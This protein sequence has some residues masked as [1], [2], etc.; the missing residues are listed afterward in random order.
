MKL[1]ASESRRPWKALYIAR[2]TVYRKEMYFPY[3][4]RY[5]EAGNER[6][7][8]LIILFFFFKKVLVWYFVSFFLSLNKWKSIPCLIISR[9]LRVMLRMLIFFYLKW[10]DVKYFNNNYNITNHIISIYPI[11]IMII[12]YLRYFF[13][14]SWEDK[15]Y[16][17][18]FISNRIF[19][20]N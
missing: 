12:Y 10:Y 9:T 11:N 20:W 3:G 16:K 13:E 2:Y 4:F 6:D 8:Y 18:N 15:W 19:R 7:F 14:R 5:K 1:A 17:K